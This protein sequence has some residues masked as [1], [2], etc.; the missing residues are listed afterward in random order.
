MST[1][2]VPSPAGALIP[3]PSMLAL[4]TDA[5]HDERA[6]PWCSTPTITE[7][8]GLGERR[9]RVLGTIHPFACRP[10]TSRETRHAYRHHDRI[11][12]T[13]FASDYCPTARALCRLAVQTR[14]RVKEYR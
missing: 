5:Q 1:T 7:S 11:C 2:P 8:I 10:C 3:M 12:T 13:C 4:M 6:C 9:L 14:P